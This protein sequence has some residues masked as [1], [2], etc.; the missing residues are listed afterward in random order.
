MSKYVLYYYSDSGL[1]LVD[2]SCKA[3]F[4]KLL[5]QT[6]AEPTSVQYWETKLNVGQRGIDWRKVFLIP[7]ISTIESYTR[8]FQYKILN[9]A[10]FFNKRLFTFGSVTVELW[11]KLQRWLTLSFVLPDLTLENALL[12]YM[13]II[14]D[15]G[16]TAKLVNHIL[17][18]LKRSLYEM[19]SRKVAPSIF[20]IM[21]KIK[22]IRDIEYQITKKSDKLTLHFNKWDLLNLQVVN[23]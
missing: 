19:R 12:G 15:N 16:T 18:I 9:N 22:Q 13:P 8:S 20:Y 6:I 4:S 1:H 11:K 3:M 7:R 10:L 14:S 2:L 21:N 5:K 17:L 23:P